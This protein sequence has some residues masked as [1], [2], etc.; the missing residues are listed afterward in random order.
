MTKVTVL[1]TKSCPYCPAAKRVWQDL[2]KDNKFDYEEVDAMSP[3][4]QRLVERHGI[5]SVPTSLVDGKVAFNGVPDK[6][7]ALKLVKK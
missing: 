1:T 6:N 2:K 4:G 7:A 5:M 3:E